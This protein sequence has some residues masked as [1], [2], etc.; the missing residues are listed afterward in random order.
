[1][2]QR[3]SIRRNAER[4]T[5]I[6]EPL[7]DRLFVGSIYFILSLV[8][9]VVSYPLIYIVSASFSAPSAVISGKVWLLPVDPTL[10]AYKAILQSPKLLAGFGNSLFYTVAGTM[11]SL[12]LSLLL[13]YPLSRRDLVG[14]GPI[15][16]YLAV[17]LVIGGGLIPMY[18]TVKYFGMLDTRWAMIIPGAIS[19]WQVIIART[20]FQTTIPDELSEAAEMDGSSDFRFFWQ[21]VI[22]L[23]K[24][25]IAVMGLMYAVGMWNSYFDA[26]IYLNDSK[27]FPLQLVLRSILVMNQVDP[28]MMRDAQQMIQAQGLS[29]LLK[30]SLIVVA[31]APVLI[32]YPFVQ[33]FFIKGIMIG[34][35]KG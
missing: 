30:Y 15:M 24:P 31:S 14:R 28:E 25:I 22:P 21:M 10:V 11:V 16:F 27:L 26:L 34:S 33:R 20:F 23:S 12:V 19:V 35:L 7:T 2:L 32:L 13:A 6:R 3:V 9:I 8:T 17:T 18:L 29:T 1:M 5:P 4:R